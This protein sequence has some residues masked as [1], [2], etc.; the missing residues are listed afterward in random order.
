MNPAFCSI[1]R[2][3]ER[4]SKS[5]NLFS[6]VSLVSLVCFLYKLSTCE[7]MEEAMNW[8]TVSI[9]VWNRLS[10]DTTMFARWGGFINWC[11]QHWINHYHSGITNRGWGLPSFQCAVEW[12]VICSVSC[13]MKSNTFQVNNRN[14]DQVLWIVDDMNVYRSTSTCKWRFAAR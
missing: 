4:G 2:E 6:F 10:Q 13:F 3:M 5:C 1:P 14:V 11:C 12:A 9:A 8:C 7:L